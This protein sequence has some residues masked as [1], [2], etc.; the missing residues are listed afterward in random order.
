MNSEN[1]DGRSVISNAASGLLKTSGNEP[2]GHSA[3]QHGQSPPLEQGQN[4]EV[5]SARRCR[6]ESAECVHR[7]RTREVPRLS[8]RVNLSRS[9]AR[10]RPRPRRM[11][12]QSACS[13]ATRLVAGSERAAAPESAAVDRRFSRTV[14]DQVPRKAVLKHTHSRRFALSNALVPKQFPCD[15]RI[16]AALRWTHRR[17]GRTALSR[18]AGAV[19]SVV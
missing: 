5:Q 7:R 10:G 8:M 6:V 4:C 16:S 1:S 18:D 17:G 9:G 2:F 15:L 11:G 3:R 19:E 13:R 14:L 12:S